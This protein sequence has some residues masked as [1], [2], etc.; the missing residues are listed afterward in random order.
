MKN[1]GQR[2]QQRVL[3]GSEVAVGQRRHEGHQHGAG[4]ALEQV[5]GAERGIDRPQLA[6]VVRHQPERKVGQ[7]HAQRGHQQHVAETERGH[8]DAAQEGATD[9]HPHTEQLGDGRDVGLVEPGVE[10]SSTSASAT[11]RASP[12][13]TPP[14]R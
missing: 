13:A 8:R 10:A 5:V 11:A 4:K 2:D 12:A 7:R 1:V 9:A 6:R 14:H 3:G